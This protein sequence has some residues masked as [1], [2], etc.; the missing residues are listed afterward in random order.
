MLSLSKGIERTYIDMGDCCE[1]QDP[2]LQRRLIISS[3][4]CQS[5]KIWDPTSSQEA[6]T[7]GQSIALA[8]GYTSEYAKTLEPGLS[9]RISLHYRIIDY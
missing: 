8:S 6:M 9:Q 7:T 1:I 5:L 4:G 3:H 2:V